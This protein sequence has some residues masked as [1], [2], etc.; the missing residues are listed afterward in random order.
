MLYI[1]FKVCTYEA[2]EFLN[3]FVYE[4]NKK[5]GAFNFKF[6]F[7]L[8]SQVR[9]S[10]HNEFDINLFACPRSVNLSLYQLFFVHLILG[11]MKSFKLTTKS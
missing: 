4:V 11:C 1:H 7:Y 8:N 9:I 5:I 3:V 2:H 6:Q 10:S